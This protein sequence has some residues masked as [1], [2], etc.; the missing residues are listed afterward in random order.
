MRRGQHHHHAAAGRRNPPVRAIRRAALSSSRATSTIHP[1]PFKRP[2]RPLLSSTSSLLP[3]HRHLIYQ[4][5]LFIHPSPPVRAS[6]SSTLQRRRIQRAG[7]APHLLLR[8]PHTSITHPGR[9]RES[10]HNSDSKRQRSHYIPF[11]SSS[12]STPPL[13]ALPSPS[14]P[15]S[16]GRVCHPARKRGQ[17]REALPLTR[18]SRRTVES[19]RRSAR[20]CCWVSRLASRDSIQ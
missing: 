5:L 15:P 8:I 2:P 1:P 12:L 18:Q 11:R 20:S 16:W 13:L 6:S 3:L 4:R 9:R 19:S 14:L 17:R 10:Q 7:R